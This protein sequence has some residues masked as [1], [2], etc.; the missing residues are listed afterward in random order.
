MSLPRHLYKEG[1]RCQRGGS[2]GGDKGL[3][4]AA[5]APLLAATPS[6]VP[7]VFLAKVRDRQE[8]DWQGLSEKKD[9]EENSGQSLLAE[10]GQ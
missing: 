10:D 7:A 4:I 6:G 8:P 9:E 2:G 1:H 5:H 3:L